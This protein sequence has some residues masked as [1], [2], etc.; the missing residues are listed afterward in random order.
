[1]LAHGDK[2]SLFFARV[3]ALPLVGGVASVQSFNYERRYKLRA[4]SYYRYKLALAD[5]FYYAV[6]QERFEEQAE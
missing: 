5:I 2:N 6:N 1:M 4:G 3:A